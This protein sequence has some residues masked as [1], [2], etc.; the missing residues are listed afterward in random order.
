MKG[1]NSRDLL[2]DASRKRWMPLSG[3][4]AAPGGGHSACSGL[5][6]CIRPSERLGTPPSRT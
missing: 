5:E 6:P 2:M 3:C 4:L 1:G